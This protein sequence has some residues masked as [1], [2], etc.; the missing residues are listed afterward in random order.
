MSI[1]ANHCTEPHILHC[2]WHNLSWF[3]SQFATQSYACA[4]Q[5]QNASQV[6]ANQSETGLLRL[7]P[8]KDYG[9]RL[10]GGGP[11]EF[12]PAKA[13]SQQKKF[14]CIYIYSLW[15]CY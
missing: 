5:S 14:M 8:S 4:N 10:G 2:T 11:R 15:L 3:A 12:W 7:Y 13:G 9:L 1:M 6:I